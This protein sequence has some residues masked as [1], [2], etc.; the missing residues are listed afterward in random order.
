L[1]IA[2]ISGLVLPIIKRGIG[3]RGYADNAGGSQKDSAEKRPARYGGAQRAYAVHFRILGHSVFAS[4]A[5]ARRVNQRSASDFRDFR[6][7]RS[8]KASH[9][10]KGSGPPAGLS[11][12]GLCPYMAV[13]CLFGASHDIPCFKAA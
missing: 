4:F 7:K 8:K 2:G 12:A 10:V 9:C 6:P 5:D 3:R 13:A 1:D 11:V